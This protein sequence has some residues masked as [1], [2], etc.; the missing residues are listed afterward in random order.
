MP[1]L[2]INEDI[3][4][5]YGIELCTSVLKGIRLTLPTLKGEDS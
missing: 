3:R 5:M 1:R 4:S 2:I